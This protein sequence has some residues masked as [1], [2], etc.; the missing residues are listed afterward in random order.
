MLRVLVIEQMDHTP[1][2]R[3][4]QTCVNVGDYVTFN[5]LPSNIIGL[6]E[7]VGAERNRLKVKLFKAMDSEA[8]QR[9][10]IKPIAATQYT[11][12]TQDGM[13][14]V[15]LTSEEIYVE[16]AVVQDVAFILSV[17]EVES[18]MFHLA[19]AANTFFI[20]FFLERGVMQPY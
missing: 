7:I 10:M 9:Y 5:P 12:A 17:E 13:L 8:V 14:E 19:G 15:Y 6:G 20:H 16:R 4:I 18:G 11:I 2:T 1:L 3:A